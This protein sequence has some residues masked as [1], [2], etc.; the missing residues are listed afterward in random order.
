MWLALLMARPSPECLTVRNSLFP[1]RSCLQILP[2]MSLGA[3]PEFMNNMEAP[4]NTAGNE[5]PKDY[6]YNSMNG[7]PADFLPCTSKLP[8][9]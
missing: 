3:G 4:Q 1:M 6:F 5:N 9:R 2:I 7:E 8:R